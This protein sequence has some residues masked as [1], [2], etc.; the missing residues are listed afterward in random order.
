LQVTEHA[1][2]FRIIHRV[3]ASFGDATFAIEFLFRLLAGCPAPR[4]NEPVVHLYPVSKWKLRKSVKKYVLG[5][6]EV[7]QVEACVNNRELDLGALEHH[8]TRNRCSY[9][10]KLTWLI[11]NLVRS[12]NTCFSSSVGYGESVCSWNQSFMIFVASFGKFP[13]LL[14]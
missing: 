1:S 4:I 3:V 12:H 11:C 10:K 8:H 6:Q 13:R 9:R 2:H 7:Q 5:W 14:R